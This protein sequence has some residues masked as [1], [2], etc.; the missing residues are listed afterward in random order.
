MRFIFRG[1]KKY[2]VA[3]QLSIQFFLKKLLDSPRG[4]GFMILI[5]ASFNISIM[6]AQVVTM[7]KIGDFSRLNR[8]SIKTLRHY[9][10]LG[11]LVPF[12]VDG[13]SGYRYYSAS[14]IPRLNRI[15]ALKEIGFTLHEISLALKNEMTKAE[16]IDALKMKKD[17]IT[18]SIHMEQ[19]KL[20]RLEAYV[21]IL[22][23]EAC[24]MNY[25]IV[26]KET[27]PS[28]IASIRDRISTY[29]AQGDLW[30][31]LAQYLDEHHVKIIAP[32]YAIYH[33]HGFKEKDIDTEVVE[34]VAE[35]GPGSDR[36]KFR[37][38]EGVKEM[39]CVI[40]KG[41][42]ESLHL[43]YNAVSV[44]LEKNKYQITGPVRECYLK[45]N[46]DEP[47]PNQWIT[48]LQFPVDRKR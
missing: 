45:G 24:Y 4:G 48:E 14:Q 22:E 9:D 2:L 39:A 47:D 44:W 21:K 12:E 28:K 19:T 27:A 30:N 17:D 42:Y 3:E 15:L 29:N 25:D 32:C 10:T 34:T 46:W 33:D 16:M 8:V 40:H 23:Q 5:E 6:R 13:Q 18:A 43:A 38:L 20:M 31:E 11:L 1:K 41:P 37:I 35:F 26:I 36:I 7:F